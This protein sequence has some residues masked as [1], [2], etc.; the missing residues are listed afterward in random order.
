MESY[1]GVLPY[2]NDW[3]IENKLEYDCF[4]EQP[5]ENILYRNEKQRKLEKNK[6]ILQNWVNLNNKKRIWPLLTFD[7]FNFADYNINIKVKDSQRQTR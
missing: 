6:D 5:Y 4:S 3:E 7:L 1:G 2:E